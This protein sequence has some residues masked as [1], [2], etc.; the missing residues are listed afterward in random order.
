MIIVQPDYS[1]HNLVADSGYRDWQSKEGNLHAIK[2]SN[3]LG[4][5]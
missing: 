1:A 4:C 5:F 3:R 2:L